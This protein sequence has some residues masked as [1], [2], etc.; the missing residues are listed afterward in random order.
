MLWAFIEKPAKQTSGPTRPIDH[1]QPEVAISSI[2][3]TFA[4]L[5]RQIAGWSMVGNH[6]RPLRFSWTVKQTIDRV[7]KQDPH[8]RGRRPHLEYHPNRWFLSARR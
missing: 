1:D 8:R 7:I 6:S 2:R 5:N 4:R 3:R